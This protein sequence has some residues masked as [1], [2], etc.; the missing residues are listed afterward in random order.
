MK[1]QSSEICGATNDFIADICKS[2]L[3][4]WRWLLMLDTVSLERGKY[5]N[6]Y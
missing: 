1:D 5:S 6:E 3:I 4:F 2:A